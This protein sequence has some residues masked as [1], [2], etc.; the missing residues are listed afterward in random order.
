MV[1]HD[2]MICQEFKCIGKATQVIT[3][4]NSTNENQ[5]TFASVAPALE[6]T[7]TG[8][9]DQGPIAVLR[10]SG[11]NSQG[12]VVGIDLSGLPANATGIQMNDHSAGAAFSTTSDYMLTF[13]LADGS[14]VLV[15][16]YDA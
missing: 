4:V 5:G 8:N 15:P 1:I 3:R 14:D 7:N 12:T 11:T 6:I 16:A 13:K 9:N 10:I 2:V